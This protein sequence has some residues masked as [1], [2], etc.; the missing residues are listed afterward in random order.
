MWND[1]HPEIRIEPQ[2]IPSSTNDQFQ[3]FIEKPADLYNLDVIHI[4]KFVDAKRIRRIKGDFSM[5]GPVKRICQVQGTQDEYWAVP[6]NTDVGMLFHR[7]TAKGELGDPP[8]LRGVLAQ[9]Q[10][11]APQFVGQLVS[12]G[13]QTD[14][15]FVV[16]VLEHALAQDPGILTEDGA[17]SFNDS[18]WRNALKPLRDAIGNK[19]VLKAAGEEKT[20]DAFRTLNLLYMRNWPGEYLVVDRP[21]RT[22]L[23]TVEIKVGSLGTGVGIL[24]GQSLAIAD[25]TR[26]PA[27]AELVVGFLT[28]PPAQKLLATYGF[29]PTSVDAYTD[30]A[31]NAAIPHLGE[32]RNA[33]EASRPRPIHRNYAE[34]AR[35]FKQYTHGYLHENQDLAEGFASDIQAALR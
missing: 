35:K 31:V 30:P 13:T 25:D 15:A 1:L 6:F 19:K 3:N 16:N 27:E 20:T 33:V 17:I 4:P 11:G 2:V 28:G 8:S 7:I 18:Q 24:G 10:P 9:A 23:D 5:L 12:G 34:F 29:A 21:E 22:E 26:H 32:I 14:E